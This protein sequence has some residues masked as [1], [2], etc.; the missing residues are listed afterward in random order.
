MLH[1]IGS[2]ATSFDRMLNHLPANWNVIV[3][4][5]PGYGRSNPLAEP[6]PDAGDYA[7]RLEDFV[8][9]LD[10]GSMV[11][12]G[13]SLGTLMAAAF[14]EKHPNRVSGLVLMACAQGYGVDRGASLPAKAAD[15]LD[16]LARLGPQAFAAE[17]APRLMAQAEKQPDVLVEAIAAMS[18]IDPAGYGQAVYA[19]SRGDLAGLVAGIALPS[20]VL[21][22]REDVITPPDQ[23]RKAHAALLSHAPDLAHEWIEIENA[24]HI[25]HQQRPEAVAMALRDFIVRLQPEL[26]RA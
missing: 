9:A 10:I 18:R 11:L 6:A 8:R 14:A 20:L 24:G 2:D 4:N 3:W 21:V 7:E 23:S 13:H 17:R 26:E 5:A 25:V 16:A 12:V 22:G 15:R 19:L 1:G